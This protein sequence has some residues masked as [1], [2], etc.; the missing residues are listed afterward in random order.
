[1]SSYFEMSYPWCF[2]APHQSP[3]YSAHTLYPQ[4][5]HPMMG[6]E[7]Y[8]SG[9]PWMPISYPSIYPYNSLPLTNYQ[10]KTHPT[11][12]D[13][14]PPAKR[15]RMEPVED[16]LPHLTDVDDHLL[17]I[18]N[19]SEA[20][21]VD[22]LQSSVLDTSYEQ[23]KIEPVTPLESAVRSPRC[24]TPVY[25]TSPITVEANVNTYYPTP[26]VSPS[27]TMPFPWIVNHSEPVTYPVL[28]YIDE[29][30]LVLN[31]LES[32]QFMKYLNQ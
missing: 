6:Y 7:S 16:H 18:S 2:T 21:S 23:I 5:P 12:V 13:G 27:M 22:S 25:P 26:P 29:K 28:T 8:I 11:Y 32:N 14:P 3:V 30:P 15:T 31:E 17:D 1:M 19:E 4:Y 24:P 20:H 10:Q 9:Y